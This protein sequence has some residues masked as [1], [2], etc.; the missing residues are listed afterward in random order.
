M[1]AYWI[2][3]AKRLSLHMQVISY[4]AMSNNTQNGKNQTY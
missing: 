1:N 3:E 2:K 4:T